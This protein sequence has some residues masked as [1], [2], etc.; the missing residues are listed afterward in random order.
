MLV[1]LLVLP[2]AL[3]HA[4][5]YPPGGRVR[6]AHLPVT[7]FGSQVLQLPL[8][9]QAEELLSLYAQPPTA[10]AA[11]PPAGPP[12]PHQHYPAAAVASNAPPHR[13]YPAAAVIASSCSSDGSSCCHLVGRM[14][15]RGRAEGRAPGRL[16]Y[17]DVS[18]HTQGK[19]LPNVAV[20]FR[21]HYH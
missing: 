8:L 14:E 7:C 11:S 2:L 3:M 1:R 5:Y 13:S 10:P 16:T 6:V 20:V 15:P 18:G 4:A 17:V 19:E 9:P 21:V 12:P